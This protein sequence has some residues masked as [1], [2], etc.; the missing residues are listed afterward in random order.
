[1]YRSAQELVAVESQLGW[2]HE[3]HAPYI[4]LRLAGANSTLSPPASSHSSPYAGNTKSSWK[5]RHEP[6][7]A[8]SP[9]SPCTNCPHHAQD[10]SLSSSS[11]SDGASSSPDNAG[12]AV[13][14]SA[15]AAGH[16]HGTCHK[17]DARDV[18]HHTASSCR[19]AHPGTSS[20][21]WW[22]SPLPLLVCMGW[23]G[24]R[25]RNLHCGGVSSCWMFSLPFLC[26]VG[27]SKRML[28]WKMLQ[29]LRNWTS[30]G[31]MASL[32]LL[33]CDFCF[34]CRQNCLNFQSVLHFSDF[35]FW[36]FS[37]S[38]F[39]GYCRFPGASQLELDEGL[40]WSCPLVWTLCVVLG[41]HFSA[42]YFD[43]TRW[44]GE[45]AGTPLRLFDC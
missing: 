41:H 3:V 25:C 44:F 17:H 34:G 18:R 33:Q 36:E 2:Y 24:L 14:D 32:V 45:L 9:A 22:W 39:A 5:H 38:Y 13:A 7:P 15:A 10:T 4:Q 29:F 16:V 23:K 11:A 40:I 35:E 1:M 42:F 20:E 28:V 6:G 26:F 21:V 37:Y 31:W 30:C 8:S 19:H 43:Q 27:R 12:T